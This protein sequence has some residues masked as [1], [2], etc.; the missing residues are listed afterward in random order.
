MNAPRPPVTPEPLTP[1][2]SAPLT[3]GIGKEGSKP[4]NLGESWLLD[5]LCSSDMKVNACMVQLTL[6]PP[7]T[8]FSEPFSYFNQNTKVEWN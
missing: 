4:V 7:N 8:Q 1:T 2:S 3:Y 6:P 5:V